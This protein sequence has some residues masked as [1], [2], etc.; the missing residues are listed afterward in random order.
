[1]TPMYFHVEVYALPNFEHLRPSHQDSQKYVKVQ[2]IFPESADLDLD[3]IFSVT[4]IRLC[5]HSTVEYE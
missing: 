2:T 5:I 1:M 4:P 3:I